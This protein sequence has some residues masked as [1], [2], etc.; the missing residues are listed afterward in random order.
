MPTIYQTTTKE[1]G[2]YPDWLIEYALFGPPVYNSYVEFVERLRYE[3]QRKRSLMA[4]R[5]YQRALKREPFARQTE[6]VFPLNLKP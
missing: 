4:I 2:Q 6:I 1:R 5:K 3:R